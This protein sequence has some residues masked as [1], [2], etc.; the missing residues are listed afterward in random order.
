[1][2]GRTRKTAQ[3][4]QT[5]ALDIETLVSL[6]VVVESFDSTKDNPTTTDDIVSET[7]RSLQDEFANL[8]ILADAGLVDG[9]RNRWWIVA[10]NVTEANAAEVA[11]KALSGAKPSTPK[12]A[13]RKAVSAPVEALT[14]ELLDAEDVKEM[15]TAVPETEPKTPAEVHRIPNADKAREI[16]AKAN[17]VPSS[18]PEPLD[19]GTK[20]IMQDGSEG[21]VISDEVITGGKFVPAKPAE[22]FDFNALVASLTRLRDDAS[23]VREGF[24]APDEVTSLPPLPKGVNANTWDMVHNAHSNNLRDTYGARLW[25]ARRAQQQYSAAA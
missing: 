25:W 15:A 13:T 23:N 22:G 10:P 20:V 9:E 17:V 19:K 7:K 4:A 6:F 3:P 21:T 12:R 2:A 24:T 8:S 14:D 18:T 11:R 5:P 16:L 1:M